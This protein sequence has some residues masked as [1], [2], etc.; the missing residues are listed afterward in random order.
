MRN[1]LWFLG[2]VAACSGGGGDTFVG[3]YPVKVTVGAKTDDDTLVI[4]QIGT[5]LTLTFAV[6]IFGDPSSATPKELRG[7]AVG[8]TLTL[9]EQVAQI[10]QG[11]GLTTGVLTGSGTLTPPAALSL[12]L[13][14]R[15]TSA[16]PDGGTAPTGD[17]GSTATQ[18]TVTGTRQ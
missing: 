5:T 9:A 12:A 16:I 6:G 14:F 11:T 13:S 7:T 18:Y 8:A 10:D 4:G 2:L 3:T 17:A 1:W 15:A